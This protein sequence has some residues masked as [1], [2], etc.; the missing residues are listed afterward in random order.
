VFLQ[1]AKRLAHT[2]VLKL[3]V[4]TGQTRSTRSCG[5]HYS[6]IAK[7]KLFHLSPKKISHLCNGVVEM[8]TSTYTA[9]EVNPPKVQIN[10]TDDIHSTM[11]EIGR[12]WMGHQFCVLENGHFGLVPMGT[13]PGDL[14]F[15]IQGVP[16]PFVV[17]SRTS[18]ELVTKR[19]IDQQGG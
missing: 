2:V 4:F 12:S 17:R 15:I 5:G 9:D 6:G 11:F 18:H 14:V 10:Y 3:S 13:I 19:K 16:T 8:V 7:P 1:Q